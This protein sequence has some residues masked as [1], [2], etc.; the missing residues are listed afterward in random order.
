M[1]I[2][3]FLTFLSTIICTFRKMFFGQN[4]TFRKMLRLLMPKRIYFS[5]FVLK[6]IAMESHQAIHRKSKR[7]IQVINEQLRTCGV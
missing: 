2:D 5:I 3:H 1:F 7:L 4:C 6:K